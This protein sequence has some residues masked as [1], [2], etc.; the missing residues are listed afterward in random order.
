MILN[1]T[2]TLANTLSKEIINLFLL[3]SDL[4]G[5]NNMREIHHEMIQAL[6]NYFDVRYFDETQLVQVQRED[7]LTIIWIGSGGTE[8]R[9]RDLFSQ[10]HRPIVLLN[11]GISNSLA[12]SLEIASWLKRSKVDFNVIH[13]TPEGIVEEI[14]ILTKIVKAR[15][16][17]QGQNI[18][19]IGE[20]SDWLI[21]SSVDVDLARNK[22]GVNFVSLELQEV[23]DIYD[24]IFRDEQK[25]KEIGKLAI[26]FRHDA[27]CQVEGDLHEVEKAVCLYLALREICLTHHLQAMT[28]RC[29]GLIDHCKTTGCLALSWLNRDGLLAGCEGDMQAIL[30]LVV[31]KAVTGKTGFMANPSIISRGTNQI[32]LSHCMVD[33]LLT[34][35]YMIRSH[36]ET[37][38]GIA[39]Q[40]MLPIGTVTIFKMGGKQ[41]DEH[42]LSRAKLDVNTHYGHFCRTQ[43]QFTLEQSV[44]YFFEA[45]IGNHHIIL[46]GDYVDILERL[47]DKKTK[48]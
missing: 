18:G 5:H 46:W 7:A 45:P 17:L 31:A 14:S 23:L 30:T 6:E 25:V 44:N 27:T 36:Y 28:L 43:A 34:D 33:P 24:K 47:F 21:A 1:E 29:F 13:D 4:V 22:W 37:Q 35:S 26:Q 8:E 15:K 9:F 3:Q 2:I 16:N 48:K 40:G 10:W 38:S 41:L 12:A 32:I 19:V 20:P 42:F 39:L 11:D